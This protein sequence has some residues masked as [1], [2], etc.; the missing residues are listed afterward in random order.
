MSEDDK[1]FIKANKPLLEEYFGYYSDTK[2]EK[3][4]KRITTRKK[5]REAGL[6]D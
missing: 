3:L 1:V 2:R 6:G 5:L 4:M